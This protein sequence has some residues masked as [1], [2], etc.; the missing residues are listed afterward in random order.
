VR[1]TVRDFA[2]SHSLPVNLQ[3]VPLFRAF[4][5]AP[6]AARGQRQIWRGISV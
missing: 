1:H 2:V 6:S 4:A 3:I 5:S